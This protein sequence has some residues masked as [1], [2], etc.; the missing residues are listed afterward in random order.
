VANDIDLLNAIRM[1]LN[2]GRPVGQTG[3]DVGILGPSVAS[4]R[5]Y[6]A[7]NQERHNFFMSIDTGTPAGAPLLPPQR[8]WNR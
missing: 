4:T 2:Q 1:G 8:R 7:P 5:N 6:Q 3:T